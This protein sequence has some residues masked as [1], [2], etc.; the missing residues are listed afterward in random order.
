[1]SLCSPLSYALN[2]LLY[3]LRLPPLCIMFCDDKNN[4]SEPLPG[5]S[6]KQALHQ[7]CISWAL[8]GSGCR[9]A[10][11]WYSPPY[12]GPM[13]TSSQSLTRTP[14]SAPSASP[15]GDNHHGQVPS[16][17]MFSAQTNPSSNVHRSFKQPPPGTDLLPLHV[18][19]AE[20]SLRS[21]T[22][23]MLHTFLTS[24]IVHMHFINI[25]LI[26]EHKCKTVKMFPPFSRSFPIFFLPF[27]IVYNSLLPATGRCKSNK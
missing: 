15:S 8:P 5:W 13:H 16:P 24:N 1:M 22:F 25:F 4:I 19:P 20:T 21:G 27:P 12:E 17:F 18:Q 23:Y 26:A 3:A 10:E 9:F 2:S 14:S 6:R 7:T 11:P